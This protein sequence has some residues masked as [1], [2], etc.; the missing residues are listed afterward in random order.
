[1]AVCGTAAERALAAYLVTGPEPPTAADLRDWLAVRL[2]DYMVPT[3]FVT[4]DRLPLTINGKVDRRALPEPTEANLP[5]TAAFVP[6]R[7]DLERR[8]AA[9]WQEVLG[10]A[11]IGTEHNF[12]ELGGH[13]LS[14]MQIISR[15]HQVLGIRLPLRSLFEQPTIGAL[16]TV[17]GA[18]DAPARAAIA[19]APPAPD[20]PLSH[21]QQ[22]LWLDHQAAGNSNYNMPE[23]FLFEEQLD[24]HVLKRALATVVERHE[25]LRTA[26]V[27]VAGEPRQRILDRLDCAI[28][29]IDV[30][31]S[32]D[33]E[34]RTREIIDQEAST[35]FDLDKPPLFRV[36]LIRRPDERHVLMM[37][38]H[39]IVGDGWSRNVL[40]RELLALYAAY[41]QGRP[42]PL[43]PL[44]IQFK[45]YAVWE[46]AQGF[47][48]QERYW[49]NKLANAPTR[50]GLPHD[51]RPPSA[52][53]LRGD[54][55][56]MVIDPAT[57]DGLRDLATRRNTSL[58]NVVLA[59]F[60]LLLFRIGGQEDLCVSM[61]VANRSHP[62][63]ET[64]LGCFVNILPIRTRL[65]PDM[66]FDQLLDHVAASTF[67][68]LEHQTYP[69]DLLV[70]RLD[71]SGGS[72]VR[73]LLDVIYAFQSGSAV[74][75]DIGAG[76]QDALPALVQSLDFSFAFAKAE[77]CLNVVDHG[78]NGLGLT[79]EYDSDLF[80]V[81]TIRNHLDSLGRFARAVAGV[82]G[83]RS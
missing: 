23:A 36:T 58:S 50:V 57:T 32:P 13:S 10:A 49:L 52:G 67:E 5:R 18:G 3:F 62:D 75:V 21:A 77:L 31:D 11:S 82:P 39:H 12:F 42:N 47:E 43:P 69:F 83:K 30:T 25:I 55:L 6:P 4:L 59:L 66:E 76:R 28:R 61:V 81:A 46:N 72:M 40:H 27:V 48:A 79:L 17:L 9:I 24:I 53:R 26:F 73:P 38:V 19:P 44:R 35:P 20:H 14:A 22:R 63:L 74:H 41:S 15:I 64:M 80:R 71:R 45:D 16:A 65:V 56:S 54:R 33:C 2:P 68:A 60:E 70:R 7:N 34:E 29:E 8:M 78:R 1:V 51:F 37:V